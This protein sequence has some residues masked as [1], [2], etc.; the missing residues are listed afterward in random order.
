MS[1][2]PPAPLSRADPRPLLHRRTRI[3][4]TT[5]SA[6]SEPLHRHH[7]RRL[8]LYEPQHRRSRASDDQ[9][10]PGC[11]TWTAHSARNGRAVHGALEHLRV[12]SGA[13]GE[14][15]TLSYGDD[16]VGGRVHGG[17]CWG[18]VG[19][20]GRDAAGKRERSSDVWYITFPRRCRVISCTAVVG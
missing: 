16:P 5:T 14:T 8:L 19:P 1:L 12:A 18:W 13:Q 3:R 11:R 2:R 6:L 4:P 15:T 17:C 20:G 10:G 7:R 9:C